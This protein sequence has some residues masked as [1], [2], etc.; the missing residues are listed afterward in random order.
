MG[1]SGCAKRVLPTAC[2]SGESQS[3]QHTHPN[4]AARWRRRAVLEQQGPAG[5]VLSSADPAMVG[6]AMVGTIK[7]Y[8]S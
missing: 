1:G 5:F 4:P 3:S 6:P 8:T 7:G 2:A